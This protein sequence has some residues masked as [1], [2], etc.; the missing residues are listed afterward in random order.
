MSLKDIFRH[1]VEVLAKAEWEA[2]LKE[3]LRKDDGDT[4]GKSGKAGE[5]S[6]TTSRSA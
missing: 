3:R 4:S 6:H 2:E 1:A 5:V